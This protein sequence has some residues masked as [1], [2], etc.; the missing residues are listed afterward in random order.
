MR[1]SFT[2]I[3]LGHVNI[4]GLLLLFESAVNLVVSGW[5]QSFIVP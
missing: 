5:S 1:A 4:V 3:F 2:K